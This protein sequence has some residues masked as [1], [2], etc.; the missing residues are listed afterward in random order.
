MYRTKSSI[1]PKKE[2]RNC[3][4]RDKANVEEGGSDR[5]SWSSKCKGPIHTSMGSS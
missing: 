1:K 5:A 4:L 2:E 3:G